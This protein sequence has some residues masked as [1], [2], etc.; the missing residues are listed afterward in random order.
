MLEVYREVMEILCSVRKLKVWQ[1]WGEQRL[2]EDLAC[3]HPMWPEVVYPTCR[4]IDFLNIFS[5]FYDNIRVYTIFEQVT[6]S[7]IL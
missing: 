2:S 7:H 3:T 5:H 1:Q 4:M 6:L